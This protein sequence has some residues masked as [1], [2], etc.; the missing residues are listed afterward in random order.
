[1]SAGIKCLSP[2]TR[3]VVFQHAGV[4]IDEA[5]TMV[6]RAHEAFKSYR[7]TT[8]SERKAIMVKALDFL[9]E[10][11]EV[12]A[13][14]LTAQMGR[15][16]SASPSELRTMRKRA[17]YYLE[18]AEEAL[19]NLPGKAEDG[20]ERWVSRE[21][22]GPVFISSAWNVSCSPGQLQYSSF[23]LNGRLTAFPVPMAHHYQHPRPGSSSRQLRSTQALA[24]NTPCRR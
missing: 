18:S 17:E 15:P 11:E 10:Q 6:D 1:M 19:S 12:L 21:P 16:I 23:L 2:S 13:N 3:E 14:E 8:L 5:T 20:F 7:K 24:T 22:V 4:L 9:T